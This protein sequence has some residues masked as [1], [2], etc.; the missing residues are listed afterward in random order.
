MIMGYLIEKLFKYLL[1]YL[2]TWS[3]LIMSLLF[4]YYLNGLLLYQLHNKAI[5]LNDVGPN[6][7]PEGWEKKI[8]DDVLM[9]WN[10]RNSMPDYTKEEISS[11]N[12]EFIKAH[13]R[14]VFC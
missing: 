14:G 8:R 4:G 13:A 6:R 7:M 9:L 11:Y 3:F 2:D 1:R 12:T 5:D 10:Q